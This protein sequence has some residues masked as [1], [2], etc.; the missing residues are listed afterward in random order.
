MKDLASQFGTAAFRDDPTQTAAIQGTKFGKLGFLR[1]LCTDWRDKLTKARTWMRALDAHFESRGVPNTFWRPGHLARPKTV[2]EVNSLVTQYNSRYATPLVHLW[3]LDKYRP[4][5]ADGKFMDVADWKAALELA[6]ANSS[7]S[8]STGK[9]PE[10]SPWA[11]WGA[12]SPADP[13]T[14]STGN[15]AS[16]SNVTGAS[17]PASAETEL[18][19]SYFITAKVTFSATAAYAGTMLRQCPESGGILWRL[20]GPYDRLEETAR[21]KLLSS[22]NPKFDKKNLDKWF[23]KCA[24]PTCTQ[25]A[26]AAPP[27]GHEGSWYA[28]QWSSEEFFDTTMFSNECLFCCGLCAFQFLA[29]DQHRLNGK[30]EPES[31]LKLCDPEFGPGKWSLRGGYH[32]AHCNCNDAAKPFESWLAL[33]E[34]TRANDNKL[35]IEHF[36]RDNM[37]RIR[38]GEHTGLVKTRLQPQAPAQPAAGTPASGEATAPPS[39]GPNVSAQV[40]TRHAGNTFWT[41]KSFDEMYLITSVSAHTP[42]KRVWEDFT[43]EDSHK[44]QLSKYVEASVE[45]FRYSMADLWNRPE[46]SEVRDKAERGMLGLPDLCYL[47][48]TFPAKTSYWGKFDDRVAEYIAKELESRGGLI[49]SLGADT[50]NVSAEFFGDSF[51]YLLIPKKDDLNRAAWDEDRTLHKTSKRGKRDNWI[52]VPPEQQFLALRQ[53]QGSPFGHWSVH[54]SVVVGKAPDDLA[55]LYLAQAFELAPPPGLRAPT[56][57]TK[58]DSVEPFATNFHWSDAD[59][60]LP[61]FPA[62]PIPPGSD[63][64]FALLKLA[65]ND[66]A[67][68]CTSSRNHSQ[69]NWKKTQTDVSKECRQALHDFVAV[70]ADQAD[71]VLMI[72]GGCVETFAYSPNHISTRWDKCVQALNTEIMTDFGVPTSRG[73][74]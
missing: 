69:N 35:V 61:P 51:N 17:N 14:P 7:A 70:I 59:N 63:A 2:A 37:R 39:A 12:A 33:G 1:D 49:P 34:F 58:H 48:R 47:M 52:S 18:G 56:T 68:G 41:K 10:V 3:E 54:R 29:P 72:S 9:A 31:S 73:K 19:R 13:T 5:L 4:T 65:F 16:A 8:S 20:S 32:Y 55:K 11:H 36:V 57:F 74:E 21:Q 67:P 23:W 38:S 28:A 15:P 64:K 43:A 25:F 62:L 40:P 22:P 24:N 26:R 66:F 71:V 53:E 45:A 46:C 44:K 42:D 30:P 60:R 6:R 50:E 27:S